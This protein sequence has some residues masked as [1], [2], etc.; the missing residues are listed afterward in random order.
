M[1]H[2]DVKGDARMANVGGKAEL[3]SEDTAMANEQF[4][5]AYFTSLYNE[6]IAFYRDGLH[7]P[8]IHSWDRSPDDRGTLIRAASGMI[9]VLAL[10]ESGACDHLFDDRVPQGAFMV[11]G[12]ERI[13][14]IHQ[15]AIKNGL[16]IQQELKNQSW[17]HRSICLREP[18][19]LMLLFVSP[20]TNP[21]H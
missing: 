12:V 15:L 4:R 17:G 6:T 2:R 11:I 21:T 18:N 19:G 7:L 14:S 13:E 1:T 8:V 16:P 9:E 5:F 20:Q 3:T 10:P